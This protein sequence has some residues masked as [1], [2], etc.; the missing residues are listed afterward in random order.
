MKKN[1]CT[2][3]ATIKL[4]IGPS[5]R[6]LI[7]FTKDGCFDICVLSLQFLTTI[8]AV[9]DHLTVSF[10]LD[11]VSLPVAKRFVVRKRYSQGEISILMFVMKIDFFF[12][13]F[14][15]NFEKVICVST[16]HGY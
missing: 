16:S 8:G 1:R 9:S 12:F 2:E 11:T 13:L 3:H 4:V 6:D 15:I 10:Y 14:Q 5:E 7:W